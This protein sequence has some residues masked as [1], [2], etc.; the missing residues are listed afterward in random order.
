[1]QRI[2]RRGACRQ[3]ERFPSGHED[4]TECK[5]PWRVRCAKTCRGIF[6]I[7]I[8]EL[9]HTCSAVKHRWRGIIKKSGW[10]GETLAP[11]VVR[12]PK[13]PVKELQAGLRMDY[14]RTTSYHQMWRAKD[15][16]HD[17][18]MGGQRFNFHLI[19]PLLKRIKEVDL[20]A[21]VD[22][23]TWEGTTVFHRAFLCPSATRKAIQYCQPVVTLDAC[24][25]KN[26]KYPMQLFLAS[27]LDGNMEVLIL[28]FA[29][30]PVENTNNWSWFLGLVDIALQGIEDTK[31]P[32]ISDRQK[33]L[34]VGVRDVFP[35][36]VHAY[37]AHHIR[38]NVKTEFG[39]AAKQFFMFCVYTN[40]KRK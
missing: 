5:C 14:K 26:R 17:W 15:H 2:S 31:V 8:Y 6:R 7:S 28:Y 10:L 33:G 20:D 18:Y 1:M 25:T 32:F 38:G 27:V 9:K 19:P 40:S 24:H 13:V 3:E 37:C 23:D 29:L 36:K 22:W 4:R 11:R 21:I 12:N 16:I 39:K 30:A 35:G 34:K